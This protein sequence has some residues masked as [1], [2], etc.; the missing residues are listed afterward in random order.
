MPEMEGSKVSHPLYLKQLIF[1]IFLHFYFSSMAYL[2][3][4]SVIGSLE[5][6]VSSKSP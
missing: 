5:R 6:L 2:W 1:K 4:M 3:H